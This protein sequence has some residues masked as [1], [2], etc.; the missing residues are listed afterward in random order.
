MPLAIPWWQLNVLAA[1]SVD[2][3]PWQL[4][5]HARGSLHRGGA[6]LAVGMCTLCVAGHPCLGPVLPG[7]HPAVP[8][9]WAAAGRIPS[10]AHAHRLQVGLFPFLLSRVGPHYPA[11][12]S[13]S[14]TAQTPLWLVWQLL[15]AHTCND[16]HG[17]LG[18]AGPDIAGVL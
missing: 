12:F 5:P 9:Q 13:W 7:C 8:G 1:H 15:T 14:D 18:R 16:F 6:E 10:E 4:K 3:S 17:A 2:L 11:W